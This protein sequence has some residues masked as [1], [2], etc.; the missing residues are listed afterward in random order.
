LEIKKRAVREEPEPLR[1]QLALTGDRAA[2][3]LLAPVKERTTAIL[4][5]RVLEAD[6]S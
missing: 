1:R 4:A 3:L 5:Q 6:E 2:V